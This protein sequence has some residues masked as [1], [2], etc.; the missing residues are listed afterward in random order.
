MAATNPPVS[1]DCSLWPLWRQYR[2]AVLQADGRVVDFK[3][4]NGVT[5]S[6]GQAYSLFFALLADDHDAFQTILNWTSDHLAQ[7]DLGRRLPAWQW[8]QLPSGTWGIR[9]STPAADADM[10]LAYTLI[11]AGRIWHRPDYDAMGRNLL[12][13]VARLETVYLPEF[14]WMILPA[15]EG[16]ALPGNRWRLNPSYLPLPLLRA[17]SRVDPTGPWNAI[18]QNLVRMVSAVAPHGVLPD[19]V[20][21]EA[22][23]GWRSDPDKGTLGSY[24]AIRV[25][26]WAGMTAPGDPHRARLMQATGGL[27]RFLDRHAQIPEKIDAR[28]GQPPQPGNARYIAAPPG[29]ASA[30][31]PYLDGTGQRAQWRV[32][33]QRIRGDLARGVG[34]VGAPLHYYDL[35]LSLFGLGWQEQ[36][37]RFDASGELLRKAKAAPCAG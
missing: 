1:G 8:G 22:G 4:D 21:Y 12:R 3:F 35:A 27:A 15:P 14:G 11:E 23:S 29:F 5:T 7:G 2:S 16:F 28:T 34:A 6:E 9:D 20:I 17:F 10:W 26:L 13:Q 30:L 25:Y 33:H 32:W 31:L 36:R 19:W 37:F 18:A 24:D